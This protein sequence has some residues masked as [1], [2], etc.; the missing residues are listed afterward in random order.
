LV[1]TTHGGV[2]SAIG[3]CT[4]ATLIDVAIAI[5]VEAIA[6][7]GGAAVLW[8]RHVIGREVILA[9]PERGAE[10]LVDLAIAVIIEVVAGLLGGADFALTVSAPRALE[11]A[12]DAGLAAHG[13]PQRS[14]VAVGGAQPQL[15]GLT[16]ALLV[17]HAVAVVVPVVSAY[18]GRRRIHAPVLVVAIGRF[19]AV[20]SEL[21]AVPVQVSTAVRC[22]IRRRVV[23][24][25]VV[26]WV[27]RVARAGRIGA[28][29][30]RSRETASERERC[31]CPPT[32]KF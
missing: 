30:A 28:R 5:V 16:R 1:L 17:G 6:L 7:G 14:G 18:L 3:E 24:R 15:A 29:R 2:R 22:V 13:G 8:R 31:K 25:R 4:G 11:A 27:V 21:R 12:L 19:R 32:G 10:F 26:W 20:R 9:E 23:R